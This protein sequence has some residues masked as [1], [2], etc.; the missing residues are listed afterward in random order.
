M[1]PSERLLWTNKI[2]KIAM[3]NQFCSGMA[4]AYQVSWLPKHFSKL[5]SK[6]FWDC[7]KMLHVVFRFPS[8]T[9]SSGMP[10][11]F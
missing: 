9:T 7:Q 4:K 3:E 8:Q 11:Q 6:L 10:Q 2:E 1:F 5:L